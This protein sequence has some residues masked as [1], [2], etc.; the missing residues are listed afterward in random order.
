MIRVL[1]LLEYVYEDFEA[2]EADQARWYVPATGV[3]SIGLGKGNTIR[4]AV[5]PE[6]TLVPVAQEVPE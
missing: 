3:R 1:R 6:T 5:L 2:A 4:S